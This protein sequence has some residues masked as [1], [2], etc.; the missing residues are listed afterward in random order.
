MQL[1]VFLFYKE[2]VSL[3]NLTLKTMETNLNPSDKPIPKISIS[4]RIAKTIG[5]TEN[6]IKVISVLFTSFS[7]F[8]GIYLFYHQD[9]QPE[10]LKN[11]YFWK[12]EVYDCRNLDE[13]RGV[14][15]LN[16]L[17]PDGVSIELTIIKKH[18]GEREVLNNLSTDDGHFKFIFCKKS[19]E[20]VEF[21][22][23]IGGINEN[24]ISPYNIEFIPS[25]ILLTI[26]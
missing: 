15:L 1:F 10:W 24:F 12:T 18:T 7:F 5:F 25:E 8:S 13:I 11:L 9:K 2:F 16:G 4:S 17:K 26:N 19:T 23:M 14:V 21:N 3:I 20:S 22:T 6:S